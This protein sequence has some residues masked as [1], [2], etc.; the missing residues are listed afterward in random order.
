MTALQDP[1]Q[2]RRFRV[3]L[4]AIM[5]GQFI[6]IMNSTIITTALPSIFHEL[7]AT[8]VEGSWT[9][10]ATVLGITVTS[11]IWGRL[12]D[13]RS[14]VA[15]L[16]VALV[17][18]V[19]AAVAASLAPTPLTLILSRGL[20]G[21]GLGGVFSLGIIVLANVTTPRER[22]RYFGW[23]S[24]V[25]LT[26]Q[27]T[28]PLIG[29]L[30]VE[31]VFGWRGCFFVIVPFALAM[32]V[33]LQFALRV[34][35]PAEADAPRIDWL[36]AVLLAASVASILVWLSFAGSLFDFGSWM[37]A[38]LLGGG[39]LLLATALV[40]EWRAPSPVLPLRVLG[41][42][43]PLLAAIAC[44]AVGIACFPAPL[45]MGMYFQIGRGLAPTLSGLLLVATA[46]GSVL[47]AFL[48][49]SLSSRTGRLRRF[50]L[51]GSVVLAVTC[52]L[53]AFTNGP[54]APLPYLVVL[55]LLFGIGQGAT[56][57]FV[58]LAGQNAVGLSQIGAVSGFMNFIQLLGGTTVLSILGAVLDRRLAELQ[59]EG[60]TEAQAY[61]LAVPDLFVVS[62]ACALVAVI[63]IVLMP[64]I[65]LRRTIDVEPGAAE[66]ERR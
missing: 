18:V 6:G 55:L 39:L 40:I 65:R 8:P 43:V 27:L 38:L 61:A 44:A 23:L 22:G 59:G 21:M 49:G 30:F 20:Q 14:P 50:L 32:L 52:A 51:T 12:A 5:I 48:V 17:I 41:G 58:V 28:G 33:L 19:V 15:L 42:R 57:Q 62:A 4:V 9:V 34:E 66:A 2:R 56:L 7:G 11:P 3:M 1:A 36:G 45:F 29:G 63:A 60:L 10:I 37:T 46:V 54:G 25:Q 64:R 26:G 13:R 47:A 53:L 16:R 24:A 35:R 31:S